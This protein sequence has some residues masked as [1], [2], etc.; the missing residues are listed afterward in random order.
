MSTASVAEP[1]SIPR[2]TASLA[3]FSLCTTIY[4]PATIF[5]SAH[6]SISCLTYSAKSYN[7]ASVHLLSERN[8]G[9]I[10]TFMLR[11]R[12]KPFIPTTAQKNSGLQQA[13]SPGWSNYKK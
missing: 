10:L 11:N 8:M 4:T 9:S 3:L 1:L 2:K 6:A 7:K 13:L 5:S 12:T